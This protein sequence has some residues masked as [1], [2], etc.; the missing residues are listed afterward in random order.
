VYEDEHPDDDCVDSEAEISLHALSGTSMRLSISME[1]QTLIALVN[2][3]STH[4]FIWWLMLL[5]S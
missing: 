5:V 4:C 1:D 2:F 3:G